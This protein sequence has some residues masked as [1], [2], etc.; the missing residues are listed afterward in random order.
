MHHLIRVTGLIIALTL[1]LAL[2]VG[3]AQARQERSGQRL[4]A[5]AGSGERTEDTALVCLALAGGTVLLAGG[6]WMAKLRR[7]LR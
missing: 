3:C 7:L 2:V 6:V 5:S 4:S 1:L